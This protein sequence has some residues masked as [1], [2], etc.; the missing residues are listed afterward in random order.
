[1]VEGGVLQIKSEVVEKGAVRCD[2]CL[3]AC[4]LHTKNQES[5]DS[6]FKQNKQLFDNRI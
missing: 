3:D 4:N 1:L 5:K 2:G 6:K